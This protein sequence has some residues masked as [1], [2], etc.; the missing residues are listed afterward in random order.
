MFDI[1]TSVCAIQGWKFTGAQSV[2][3]KLKRVTIFSTFLLDH[4]CIT[5]G[6]QH[7]KFPSLSNT[8]VCMVFTTIMTT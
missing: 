1:E 6:Y 4:T 2:T 5:L 7:V 3:I 8:N